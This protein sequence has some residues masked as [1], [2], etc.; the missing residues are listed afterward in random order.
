MHD[1]ADGRCRAERPVRVDLVVAR[2]ADAVVL[3]VDGGEGRFDLW[4]EQMIGAL[5]VL[6]DLRL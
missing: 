1:E 4:V 3:A 5:K 2:G 6:E